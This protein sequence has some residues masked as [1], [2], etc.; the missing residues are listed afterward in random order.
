MVKTVEIS[1]E[2]WELLMT[3]KKVAGQ[4]IPNEQEMDELFAEC[5]GAWFIPPGRAQ[6]ALQAIK[7]RVFARGH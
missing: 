5:E 2:A 3:H 1:D 6:S 4:A 7:D